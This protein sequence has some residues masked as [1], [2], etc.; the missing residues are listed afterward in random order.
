MPAAPSHES[1]IMTLAA[2]QMRPF[3]RAQ[4][5]DLEFAD[6]R[7]PRT[8]D[9][10][11]RALRC[12]PPMRR[13]GGRRPVGARIAA[14]LRV[15]ALTEETTCALSVRLRC[16][17]PQC[18]EPLRGRAAARRA[19]RCGARR[20]RADPPIALADA[21]TALTLRRPTGRR[22][23]RA[24]VA[25]RHATRRDAVRAMLD[26]AGRRGQRGA[27]RRAGGRRRRCA[28]HDPLVAL[29]GRP[30]P[31]RRAAPHAIIAVDLE[32]LA[33]ARLGA[34]QRALLRGG[35]RAGVA[36][37]LDRERSARRRRRRAAPATS[38]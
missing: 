13:S 11:A 14:L 4:D 27:R 31:A 24:G 26:D 33:L 17:Q 32:A 28:A 3:G 1:A 35:A 29:R 7:P 6:A 10:A 21:R 5:L 15:L 36:L 18:G 16:A 19:A 25:R 9:R 23:A 20:R 37:R 30:A 12:A 22:S 38:R 2:C 34:R 8:R